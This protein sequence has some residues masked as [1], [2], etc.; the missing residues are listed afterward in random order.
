[1][2]EAMAARNSAASVFIR[3][4]RA[5]G[6]ARLVGAPVTYGLTIPGNAP[7]KV[8]VAKFAAFL[9]SE[10]RQRLFAQRG[11]RP[12][13]PVRCNPCVGLPTELPGAIRPAG[14]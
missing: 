1:M 3:M 7:H 6:P 12:L 8:E 5:Q 2:S 4:K 9:F 13:N 10:Q 11:F 14:P